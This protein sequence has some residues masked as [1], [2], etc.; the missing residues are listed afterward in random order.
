MEVVLGK[1]FTTFL[2]E[3]EIRE[4]WTTSVFS[5]RAWIRTNEYEKF[6]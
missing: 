1:W 4:E 5:S 3:K 6:V 2:K